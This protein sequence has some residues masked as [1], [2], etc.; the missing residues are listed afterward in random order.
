MNKAQY[1]EDWK[2]LHQ[3][4][5]ARQINWVEHLNDFYA[6]EIQREQDLVLAMYAKDNAKDRKQRQHAAQQPI[7]TVKNPIKTTHITALSST[8]VNYDP[9]QINTPDSALD[10]GLNKAADTL[11]SYAKQKLGN[12]PTLAPLVHAI[13]QACNRNVFLRNL[14]S[15][16]PRPI[17]QPAAD[18]QQHTPLKFSMPVA[19]LHAEAPTEFADHMRT[20]REAAPQHIQQPQPAETLQ[21]PEH[22]ADVMHQAC[23]EAVALH[24]LNLITQQLRRTH[25]PDRRRQLINDSCCVLDRQGLHLF[26]NTLLIEPGVRQE[27]R[28]AQHTIYTQQLNFNFN[29]RPQAVFQATPM[30]YSSVGFGALFHNPKNRRLD[31]LEAQPEQSLWRQLMT[32]FRR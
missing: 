22:M 12:S 15:L 31:M 6:A 11:V 32:P 7:K 13:R 24:M 18:G 9:I 8:A 28:F 19:P 27:L 3:F 4:N 14:A 10:R 16:L 30:P 26:T 25:D 29:P 21:R 17:L 2:N 1:D 5:H 20:I 23:R